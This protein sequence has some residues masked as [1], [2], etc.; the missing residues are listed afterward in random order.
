[1]QEALVVI[2]RSKDQQAFLPLVP[3]TSQAAEDGGAVIEG[4]CGYSHTG[5]GIRDDL[6][7]KVCVTR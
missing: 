5:F 3:V 7:P 4:M 1:V 2:L 6:A